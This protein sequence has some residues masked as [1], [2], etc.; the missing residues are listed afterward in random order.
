[1]FDTDNGLITQYKEGNDEALRLLIERYTSGLYTFVLRA[2]VARDNAPDVV[3]DTW[4][5]AW[6]HLKKFDPEKASFKT[7][8][9]K[10]ARNTIVDFFR[11]KKSILFSDID[12]GD[13]MF[14]ET[15]ADTGILPEEVLSRFEDA[16]FLEAQLDTLSPQYRLILTLYYQEEMTLA[17]IAT[18]LKISP[19]TVKSQHLRAIKMLRKNSAPKE[20]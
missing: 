20:R 10:I 12:A 4:I 16:Q 3:Q 19:N 17:E 1:M 6:S 5:K 7:W 11:K 14:S 2:G 13:E 8:L 15:I 18:V 9:F